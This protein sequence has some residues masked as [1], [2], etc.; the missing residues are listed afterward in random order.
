MK[1]ILIERMGFGVHV[2]SYYLCRYGSRLHDITFLGFATDR[3]TEPLPNV[4]VREVGRHGGRVARYV[5]LISEICDEIRRGYDLVFLVY[6]PGCSLLKVLN[7]QVR[8]VFDIRSGATRLNRARRWRANRLLRLEASLFENVTIISEGLRERLGFKEQRTTLLPLGGL[9][10]ECA[11]KRFDK[12][13]LLYIGNITRNRRLDVTVRGLAL[14]R[15]KYGLDD[16]EV[17][18]MVGDGYENELTELRALIMQLGLQDHV[19][20]HGYIPRDRVDSFFERANIGV[21][22][23]PI[24]EFFDV[25]PVTKTYEYLLSGMPVLATATTEN[26]RVVNAANGVLVKDTPEAFADGL[27]EIVANRARYDPANIKSTARCH[28]WEYL[29]KTIYLPYIARVVSSRGAKNL[30]LGS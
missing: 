3:R 18:D 9:S 11:A 5:R 23:V 20:T 30:S 2:G 21:S 27:R 16:I 14:F 19:R 25:Q 29:M 17:Y 15:E 13:R 1:I 10:V 28:S 8:F 26:T 22:F 12:I 6:F 24:T 7:P 4:R